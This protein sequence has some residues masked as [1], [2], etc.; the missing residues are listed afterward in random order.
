MQSWL[1]RG[2]TVFLAL[3]AAQVDAIS[4]TGQS[5]ALIPVLPARGAYYDVTKAGTGVSVDVG[6]NGFVFL[7]YFGY[8]TLGAPT[9]HMIQGQWMP[10]NEAQRIQTGVIGV[11][12]SP[13][14]L[15]TGG[16]CITCD[17][18][19]GP[20]LAMEPYAVSVSWTTPRHLDLSI[21]DQ[22]WHMDA[23]QY[24]IADKD[25]LGGTWQLTIS[26]DAGTHGNPNGSGVA[27][28]TQI[29][30]VEPGIPFGKP[31][32]P[33]LVTLDQN[34]DPAIMLPPQG[35]EYHA[36]D[37]SVECTPGPLRLGTFGAAF[38]DI[39]S[40][41][42]PSTLLVSNPPGSQ[43]LAPM[44]WYDPGTGR[45]GLDVVTQAMG[46]DTVPLALGP[47]NVHFDLYVEP[48]RVIG[49]GFVQGQNLNN[50]P[51]GYWQPDSVMLNL[52]MQR[53]P[54]SLVETSIYPCLLL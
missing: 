49:H 16:Q 4:I 30:K 40:A 24:G 21:G 45:G 9:W 14:L 42:K 18:T 54:D 34:A 20:T 39:F 46:I 29:V 33:V 51:A 37:Q 28:S 32:I 48:D 25:L 10:S 1:L 22:L 36:V 44:L 8:D 5:P 11:L 35:S 27:A 41:I 52:I 43:Y 2:M 38:K 19:G 53:L 17:F 26:W 7:T 23:V 50:I 15:A 31:Q 6:Q 12:D 3:I 47:N 13:F